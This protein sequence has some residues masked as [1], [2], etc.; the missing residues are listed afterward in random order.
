MTWYAVGAFLTSFALVVLSTPFVRRYAVKLGAIDRPNA[1]KVHKGKVPRLGGLAIIL[2]VVI[3]YMLFVRGDSRLF[4][5]IIGGVL[6]GLLGMIDDRYG[7]KP[8][9]K[10][11]GQ[12]TAALV[13]VVYGVRV[14]FLTVPFDG[15]AATRFLSIPLTIIWIVGVTN[16]VNLVDG[17]DG[18]AAGITAVASVV[19]AMIAWSHGEHNVAILT[20]TLCG[21][22]LAFLRYN[23]Y[24]ASI[25][26]GDTGSMFYGFMLAT[27]S[28]L[29]MAKGFTFLSIVTA[30]FILAVPIVDTAAAIV[31][32]FLNGRPIMAPDRGHLHHRLLDSGL[33]HVGTVYTVY[34]I[35]IASGL[36]AIILSRVPVIYYLLAIA[37]VLFI[38]IGMSDGGFRYLLSEV[39]GRKLTSIGLEVAAADEDKESR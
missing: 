11:V 38:S 4:G 9:H 7:L 37:L 31:R 28:I 18:L 33:G 25:F 23:S 27:L 20:L 5:V 29:A 1:R 21:S 32:R 15:I 8:V 22:A 12:L 36:V 16:A 6:V 39:N 14:D 10:L 35:S 19:I 13:V 3:A 2:G 26:M 24:P 34:I 30:F 17:L